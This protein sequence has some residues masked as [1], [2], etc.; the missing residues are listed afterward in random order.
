MEPFTI[1]LLVAA[2]LYVLWLTIFFTVA[3]AKNKYQDQGLIG[4]AIVGGAIALTL[5]WPVVL[6]IAF[7]Y[8]SYRL[9]EES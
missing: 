4:G 5:F 3:A 8:A 7:I 1:Y 2:A 9:G 6:V